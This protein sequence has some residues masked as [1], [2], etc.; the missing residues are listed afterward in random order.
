VILKQYYLGCLAHASYL[1]GD[2]STRG[3]VI[4]DPQRDVE[5]YLEDAE[6]L[7]LEIRYVFLTHFH[8]DFLAGHLE[9]RD[10][11][12][13]RICLG[14]KGEAE[15]EFT[16]FADGDELGVG[17][18]RLEAL[19]TPGHTPEGISILVYDLDADAEKPQAVLTGDTL[20]IGDVGRPDLMASKGVTAEELAGMLYH[21]L[22]DKLLPLPDETLIYPAHGAGSLCG[23]NMSKETVSTMGDQ[24]RY[25]YA[26]QPMDKAD[27]IR[28]VTAD[29]PETPD[30]FAYDAD[31]NRRERETLDSALEQAL[32][33]LSLEEVLRLGNDGAQLVDT[34]DPIEYAAGHLAGSTN[35][36]LGGQ[37]ATWAGT[38]L[39]RSQ[40]I[41]I[42]TDPGKEE[43]S[44][45]RLGR[46]GFDHV[47]G[48]LE[49]GPEALVGR[50]DLVVSLQ[51]ITA[52]T[53][54]ELLSS[55][56]APLVLDV[57]TS[58]EW[59]QRRISGSLNIPLSRLSER[60]DELPRH[61]DIV[62]QC[63]SGYRS[64]IGASLLLQSGFRGVSD[65]VGGMNAWQASQLEMATGAEA[66]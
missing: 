32:K 2:E 52:L 5:Q 61:R 3:A 28:L 14:A 8:A 59:Q 38:L 22:H 37:Y 40:P 15:F 9:L 19:E 7:G 21:S 29:L 50:S 45:I 53:L 16:P 64:S 18:V 6:K 34:R 35:I 66:K 43:E 27:F 25:N 17:R 12:G 10:R 46:I 1:I 41:V 47:R 60:L 11:A 42:I 48:F 44:A 26:L 58:G 54:A 20:F 51:R 39:N 57:S 23:R 49:G 56:P 65:L 36:G 13:A 30:Y 33:P 62:V 4:V 55:D 31:L 24:R 63:A